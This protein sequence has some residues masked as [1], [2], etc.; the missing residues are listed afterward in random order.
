[1]RAMSMLTVALIYLLALAA[2]ADANQLANLDCYRLS[3]GKLDTKRILEDDVRGALK[4]DCGSA[5]ENSFARRVA[6]P[7]A[8]ART[9][10]RNPVSVKSPSESITSIKFLLRKDL[11]DVGLFSDIVAN[12]KADGA[13]VSWTRDKIA[14]DIIWSVDGLTALA[15]TYRPNDYSSPVIGMAV[16]P[17]VHVDKEF[18]TKA[19]SNE[20][21][22]TTYGGSAEIGFQNIFGLRGADYFRARWAITDDRIE[23]SRIGHV[24]GEW[25]PTYLRK[26]GQVLGSRLNANFRPELKVQYDYVSDGLDPLLFSGQ[27]ESLRVGPEATLLLNFITSD[28]P[29][30]PLKEI[31]SSV[32]GRVTY[33]WWT[34]THSHRQGS[35]LLGS[36]V[37]NLDKA[38]N[39]ALATTYKKGTQEETGKKTD[40]FKIEL[41]VKTCAELTSMS[42]CGPPKEE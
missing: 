34:E 2:H 29:A 3:N 27:R 32:H 42:L 30:S 4:K 9:A 38:G 37:H 14:N 18:H 24:T 21:D 41:T 6:T 36:L 12:E 33:H 16:A 35:W 25:V 26:R 10:S 28:M 5:S 17:Y 15:F 11:A 23:E 20:T 22:L 7:P 8:P 13:S 31:L 19:K 39:V 1:M 40:I